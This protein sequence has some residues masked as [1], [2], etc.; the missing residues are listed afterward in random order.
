MM[1]SRDLKKEL[2]LHDIESM[3][4]SDKELAGTLSVSLPLIYRILMGSDKEQILATVR[5]KID[6]QTLTV[7]GADQQQRWEK[8]WRENLEE[9]KASGYDEATLRPKYV[10]P[11]SVLRLNGEYIKAEDP[12][13]EDIVY[14]VLRDRLFST[15]LSDVKTIYEF[16][17]GTGHNLVALAKKY[18]DKALHGLDWAPQSKEILDLLHVKKGYSIE[19]HLFD[20]FKPDQSFK[21]VPGSGVLMIGALE[22]LGADFE[23]ILAY[24]MAQKPAIVVQINQFIEL[25]DKNNQLDQLAIEFE[26]RRNYLNGYIPRLQELEKQG[27]IKILKLRRLSFGSLFHDGYSF[28]AW[29]PL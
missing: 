7:S 24:T 25:Y 26:K 13:F 16:G 6:S 3:F 10:H 9:F 2:T 4:G 8:G 28:V 23:P 14:R 27:K 20:M 19:G 18:P 29:K 15:Y 17:C 5:Q 21:L 1:S 11:D 12:M 22:Q